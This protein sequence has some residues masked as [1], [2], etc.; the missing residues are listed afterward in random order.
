MDHI[1]TSYIGTFMWH[2]ISFLKMG[3]FGF[4]LSSVKE[5]FVSTYFFTRF[6]IYASSFFLIVSHLSL[7]KYFILKKDEWKEVQIK[8][9]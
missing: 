4:G 7:V 6:S 3:M 2:F 5:Q 1:Q 8:C 9:N